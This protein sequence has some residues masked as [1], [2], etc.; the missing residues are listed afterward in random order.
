MLEYIC[1]ALHQP[2]GT[3]P[4]CCPHCLHSPASPLSGEE[5][6][7]RSSGHTGSTCGR[8]SEGDDVTPTGVHCE[9]REAMT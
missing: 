6:T 3:D 1:A 4:P 7:D 5:Q 8:W 2:G 9:C